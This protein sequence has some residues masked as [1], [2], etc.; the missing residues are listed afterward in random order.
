MQTLTIE[1]VHPSSGDDPLLR[2]ESTVERATGQT[3][4]E[5]RSQTLT[6]LRDRVKLKNGGKLVIKSHF[7]L[8]GRGSV[9][10]EN[11]VDHEVVEAE[12]CKALK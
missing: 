10:R 7:P 6:Q 4:A 11:T 1:A 12:L 9:M 8:I 2:L 3:A 5:L